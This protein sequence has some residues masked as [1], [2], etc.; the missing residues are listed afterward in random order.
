MPDHQWDGTRL[1]FE[2]PDGKWGKYVD[3]RG[4][5]GQNGANGGGGGSGVTAL[6]RLQLQTLLGI[7]G[8]WIATPPV[9]AIT[10]LSADD[11]E[12][13]AVGSASGFYETIP[14]GDLLDVA[15]EWDWGDG[16][17]SSTL[18]AS[19]EY[20]E[21]G[22]YLV[23]FRAKNHIGW[24][25]P[26]TQEIEVSGEAPVDPDPFWDNVVLLL[27]GNALTDAKGRHTFDDFEGT[28]TI[29]DGRLHF[30]GASSLE[31]LGNLADL[32]F[33]G[34]FTI[35]GESYGAGVVATS[36]MVVLSN[37]AGAG[38]FQVYCRGQDGNSG[39][40]SEALAGN[41]PVYE[42]QPAM[43]DDTPVSW[44]A[45]R[46]GSEFRWYVSG[47]LEETLSNVGGSIAQSPAPR[48]FIGRATPASAQN[49]Q[50]GL[51]MRVT[52]GVARY[53]GSSYTPP[54]WPLPTN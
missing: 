39:F 6:E 17:T 16:A 18:N 41:A 23:A 12:V 52:K 46:Q 9:V 13:T 4:R 49:Y 1:R 20:A 2:E 31:I 15:Y 36:T 3:L 54:T 35:E 27:N 10:T 48:A 8:G 42:G 53:A 43:L 7:F 38:T 34:D 21:D 30:D 28:V 19:H 51:R 45:V 47:V 29:V 25:E 37:Y 33:A 5:P 22:T 32:S 44:A 50:G 26:V 24:S 14:G 40:Y 11:L